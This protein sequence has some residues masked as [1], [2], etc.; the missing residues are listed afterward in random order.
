MRHIPKEESR[1]IRETCDLEI[2]IEAPRGAFAER[3]DDQPY[4]DT[5]RSHVKIA[6]EQARRIARPRIWS[7]LY[8]TK[9]E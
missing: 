7:M 2:E 4:Q 6:D 5:P 8:K 3:G 9:K 1:P